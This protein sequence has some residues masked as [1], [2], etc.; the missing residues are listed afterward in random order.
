[1]EINWKNVAELGYKAYSASTN[2]KNFR[3]EE[4]P[5]FEDLPPAIVEAWIAAAKE[6]ASVH[7]AACLT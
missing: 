3:G 1:M 4:M 5:K 7:A 6:I 2:N